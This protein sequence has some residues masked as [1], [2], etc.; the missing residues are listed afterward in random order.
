MAQIAAALTPA[1]PAE[2]SKEGE[3]VSLDEFKKLWYELRKELQD[4][5]S[6]GYSEAARKWAVQVGLIQGNGKLPD[7]QPNYMWED[8]PTREQLITVMYRFAQ[9]IG[10]A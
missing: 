10:A 3:S 8:V 7:G 6:S 9:I 1:A 4:N 2:Q 5:D